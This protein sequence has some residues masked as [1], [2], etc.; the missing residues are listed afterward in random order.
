MNGR[1]QIFSSEGVF[2]KEFGELGDSSG[3]FA[4]PKGVAV[5]SDGHIYVCDAQLDM[6]QVFDETGLLLLTF[7]ESGSDKRSIMFTQVRGTMLATVFVAAAFPPAVASFAAAGSVVAVVLIGV[8]FFIVALIFVYRSFYGM[9]IPEE[10]TGAEDRVVLPH[11]VHGLRHRQRLR[12]NALREVLSFE[13][14]GDQARSSVTVETVREVL[15]HVAQGRSNHEISQQLFITS[16]SVKAHVHNIS[17]KLGA[18]G[19]YKVE[20]AP[21]IKPGMSATTKVRWSVRL[22]TPSCGSRV[23]KG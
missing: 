21:S 8:F 7:G 14:L 22:T 11:D 1:V 18:A 15:D 10:D 5:D 2:L 12:S 20:S 9:R 17:G 13:P 16:G 6:V 4:K 19:S 3:H 23:V